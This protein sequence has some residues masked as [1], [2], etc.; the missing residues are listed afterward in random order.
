MHYSYSIKANAVVLSGIEYIPELL[1]F[2][3]KKLH[4]TSRPFLREDIRKASE[5]ANHFSD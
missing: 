4:A 5:T 2:A 1:P 3:L